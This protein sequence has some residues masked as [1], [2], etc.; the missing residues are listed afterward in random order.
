MKAATSLNSPATSNP[1]YYERSV[2]ITRFAGSP[3]AQDAFA[4]QPVAA[5]LTSTTM[6]QKMGQKL[7]LQA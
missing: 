6:G 2:A 5:P 1:H 4:L 3:V 7:N